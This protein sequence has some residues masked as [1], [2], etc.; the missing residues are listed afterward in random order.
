MSRP[1]PI[2]REGLREELD[3][4]R[5]PIF[6]SKQIMP[7]YNGHTVFLDLKQLPKIR[8]NTLGQ[9]HKKE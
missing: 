7:D 9:L 6:Q 4:L 8:L 5:P 3:K 1:V 2:L